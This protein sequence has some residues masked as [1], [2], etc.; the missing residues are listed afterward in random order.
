[1]RGQHRSGSTREQVSVTYARHPARA[2]KVAVVNAPRPVRIA[3]RIESQNK[4]G[5]F[6]PVGALGRRIE[7][8]EVDPAV[9]KVVVGNRVASRRL[10][11]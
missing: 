4:L 5:R 1:M 6:G 7:E 10:V 3:P 2:L 8:P 9:A 11:L